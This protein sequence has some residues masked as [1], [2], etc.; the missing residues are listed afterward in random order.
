MYIY[1]YRYMYIYIIYILSRDSPEHPSN[2]VWKD[3]QFKNFLAM[4]VTTR[5]NLD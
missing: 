5:H 2:L 1:T 4:T 3:F